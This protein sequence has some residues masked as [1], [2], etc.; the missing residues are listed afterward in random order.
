MVSNSL[1]RRL[2]AISEELSALRDEGGILAEQIAF[3]RDVMEESRLRALVAETPLADRDLRLASETV[4]RMER[5]AQDVERRFTRLM[6]E[7]DR[8]LGQVPV[9]DPAGP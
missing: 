2:T 4:D 8:L 6:A 3:A 9:G 5:V 1:H 7:Q